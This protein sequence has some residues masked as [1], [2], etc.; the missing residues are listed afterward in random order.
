MKLYL[1]QL[2]RCFP[3]FR[4]DVVTVK[5]I[6]MKPVIPDRTLIVKCTQGQVCCMLKRVVVHLGESS[7]SGHYISYSC[8]KYVEMV[9]NDS[10]VHRVLWNST[11]ENI[12]IGGCLFVYILYIRS[13]L[14]LR[15][16]AQVLSKF[17]GE[18]RQSGNLYNQCL[19]LNLSFM[20]KLN[21]S[22]PGVCNRRPTGHNPARQAI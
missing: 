19:L 13:V 15:P 7:S 18:D 11:K 20:T 8:N 14:A 10:D 16:K 12:S 9:Y 21:C 5:K 3:L 4:G 22:T 1:Q 17:L 2:L 6:N